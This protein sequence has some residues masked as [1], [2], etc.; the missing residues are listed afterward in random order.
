[1]SLGLNEIM[2]AYGGL[3]KMAAIL[4]TFLD[5]FSSLKII[6]IW[7]QFVLKG[8]NPRRDQWFRYWLQVAWHHINDNQENWEIW[9]K[10]GYL[11][12][13]IISV[14]DGWGISCELALRW[15][16]RDLTDDKSTLVLV[17]AWCHQAT[18][19][20]LSQ[21]WPR[22]LSPYDVT[23]PQ[24]VDQWYHWTMM[25]YGITGPQLVNSLWP[26]DAIWRHRSGSTLAQVMACCL[27]APSQYLIQ[28]VIGQ[29]QWQAP[30]GNFTRD[31]SD[32]NY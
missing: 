11:I 4:E 22:S 24:W 3:N 18:S 8:P 21:C 20:Y 2:L 1:M 5:A 31:T 16:S 26:S 29:V 6:E 25:P 13:Q 28:L 14:I 15:M 32:I 12:F 9:M 10:F 19:H 27:T 30:G 7:Q 23:R 17:M